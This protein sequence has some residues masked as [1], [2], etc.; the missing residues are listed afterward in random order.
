MAES[1]DNS[2]TDRILRVVTKKEDLPDFPDDADDLPSDYEYDPDAEEELEEVEEISENDLLQFLESER[3]ALS[4]AQQLFYKDH[5]DS[6]GQLQFQVL[7]PNDVLALYHTG[8]VVIDNAI[9]QSII[10]GE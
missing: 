10:R 4:V 1:V 5:L 8:V 3:S 7:S 6:L 2:L 9:D